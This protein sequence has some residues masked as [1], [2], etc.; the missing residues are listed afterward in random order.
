MIFYEME[1]E[2]KSNLKNNIQELN[3]SRKLKVFTFIISSGFYKPYTSP[4]REDAKIITTGIVSSKTDFLK[5]LNFSEFKL[6]DYFFVDIKIKNNSNHNK[7]FL[8]F[9][10]N[11]KKIFYFNPTDL[12]VESVLQYLSV[13]NDYNLNNILI[14]GTGNIGSKLSIKLFEFGHNIYFT[15]RN[16]RL[17]K[18][19]EGYIDQNFERH[20]NII[21]LIDIKSNNMEKFDCV[22]SCTTKKNLLSSLN[23]NLFRETKLVIEVGKNN[24]SKAVIKKLHEEKIEILRL[25]ITH[26]LL[27]FLNTFIGYIKNEIPKIG[28]KEYK[29]SFVISGGFYGLY[30]DIVVDDFNNP[31]K[32]WGVADGHGKFIRSINLKK[33]EKKLIK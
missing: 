21:K 28:R 23:F 22:I 31:K 3:N 19:L 12:T 18:I 4:V 10:Q 6:I 7:K 16:R 13:K 9:F 20:H 27:G 14:L 26:T 24:L 1:K 2:F 29:N 32:V 25:S 11:Q 15:K 5:L 33:L 30:G 17:G 8:N